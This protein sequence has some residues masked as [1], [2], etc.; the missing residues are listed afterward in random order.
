MIE[1]R[2][3]AEADVPQLA[4]WAEAFFDYLRDSTGDPYFA[5][6]RFSPA[7]AAR[8]FREALAAGELLLI[9]V[10]D[11]VAVGYILAYVKE[12]YVTESP[13]RRIG[14]ISHCYVVPEARGRS[15]ATRLVEGAERWFREQGLRYVE[16]SYQLANAAAAATWGRLG[17]Q[18]FRVFARKDLGDA[19]RAMTEA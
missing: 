9:G 18:P 17:Y 8:R 19:C 16:L 7:D 5:G 11:G 4:A 14:H 12:P 1:I 10:L 2:A 6:A 13:V 15:V 3:A